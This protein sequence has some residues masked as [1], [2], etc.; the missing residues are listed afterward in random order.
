MTH[1]YSYSPKPFG[2]SLS[3]TLKGDKLT[4]DSGRKIY[5]V[6]LGTADTV[7]MTWPNGLSGRR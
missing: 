6:E 4:I 3:F 2:G 1:R 5:E 7:R